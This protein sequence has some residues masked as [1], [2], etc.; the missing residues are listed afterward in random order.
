M[1]L[2]Q[3]ALAAFMV[4][5]VSPPARAGAC[6]AVLVGVVETPI[7]MHNELRLADL[8]AMSAQ[9]GRP[10]AHPVLGFYAGDVGYSL[11]S[12]E[13]AGTDGDGGACPHLAVRAR[14]VALNRRV[15]VAS[16]LS[17]TPCRHQ[18][19][20]D[21]YQKH[22]TAASSALHRLVSELPRGL[23]ADLDSYLHNRPFPR[24]ANDPG[25]RA[26]LSSR[27]DHAVET[28][29][30]TLGRVHDDVDSSDEVRALF[31]PCNDS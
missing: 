21:H 17:T 15:A 26:F 12:V 4:F 11:L 27:L 9:L 22:A 30:V 1:Q 19:A 25:L 23:T 13:I 7:V 24:E 20:V 31:A 18:A 3:G 14:L 2:V 6:S 16:D 29:T 10:T 5:V 8:R 28:F